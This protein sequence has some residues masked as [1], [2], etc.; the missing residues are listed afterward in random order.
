MGLD[1]SYT[2]QSSFTVKF[3]MQ[4][5][6]LGSVSITPIAKAALDASGL[7]PSALLSRHQAGDWGDLTDEDKADNETSLRKGYQI[8][9]I[10]RIQP[11]TRIYVITEANRSFTRILLS[12]EY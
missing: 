1:R 5:F 10:Y 7:A 11:Q 3:P 6:K 9:S 8:W 12:E 4:K 2:R